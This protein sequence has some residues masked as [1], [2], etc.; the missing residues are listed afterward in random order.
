MSTESREWFNLDEWKSTQRDVGL[1]VLRSY[2]L[3]NESKQLQTV[4]IQVGLCLYVS[5]SS[6]VLLHSPRSS[7]HLGIL[8]ITVPHF[9]F[10]IRVINSVCVL[11]FS[12]LNFQR[13]PPREEAWCWWKKKIAPCHVTTNLVSLSSLA[14]KPAQNTLNHVQR[15]FK[16]MH[17]G[18][19]EKHLKI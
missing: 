2:C 8:H 13:S 6:Y 5:K 7:F 17:F 14:T 1:P 9:P 4:I 15:S 16:V 3:N 18:I 19:T 10:S 12:V 11:H